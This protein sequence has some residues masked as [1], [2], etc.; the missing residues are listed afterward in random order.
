MPPRQSVANQRCFLAVF[1]LVVATGLCVG[2]FVAR[3]AYS[4]VTTYRFL[5]WNL[6][7]AWV[8]L[9]CALMAYNLRDRGAPLLVLALGLG[10]LL[11]FPNAPYLMTDLL[12]LAPR[13][14]V[15]F[16]FDTI[17]LFAFAVT[18]LM[19]GYLSLYL[20]QSVV[21]RSFGGP[22][23]W[24]FVVIVLGLC[25]FG[26]YLGRFERYNSWDVLFNTV[27]LL[28]DIWSRIRHP[29]A[30]IRTYAISLILTVFLAGTYFALYSF[31]RLPHPPERPTRTLSRR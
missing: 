16:W 15:P 20:M 9:A 3:V 22:V 4:G 28:M 24:L 1:W 19:L 13:D 21:S 8:P 31:A 27:D 17:M 14:D 11:F 18:G 26:I 25:A 29:F 30:H 5:L 12:H 7:L 6:I 23:G 10:W 2:M